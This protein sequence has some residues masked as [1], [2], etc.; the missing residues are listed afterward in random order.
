MVVAIQLILI[1]NLIFL[2]MLLPSIHCN[3]NHNTN[4]IK[5]ISIKSLDY[6]RT[7]V[8]GPGLRPDEI[9][10]PVRYFFIQSVDRHGKE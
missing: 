4:V 9:V 8:W 6:K 10:T 3:N 5:K 1:I 7:K 2:L